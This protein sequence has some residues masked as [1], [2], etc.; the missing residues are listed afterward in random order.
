MESHCLPILLYAIESLNMKL[1]D[2][3][4]VN[5]WWNSVYRKIFKYHKWESVRELICYLHRLDLKHIVNLRH[6]TFIKSMIVNNS[7]NVVVLNTMKFY[8]HG[9]ECQSSF[10]KFSSNLSWSCNKIKA[11]MFISYSNSIDR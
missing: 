6:L 11:M 7:N 4:T 3:K 5:S 8:I 9:A 10:V 2:I 1:S